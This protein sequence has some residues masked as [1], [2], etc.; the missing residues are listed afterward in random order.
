M[1]DFEK[2]IP[3]YEI[4]EQDIVMER[5]MFFDISRIFIIFE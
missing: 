5:D 4:N 2:W 1:D 3:N